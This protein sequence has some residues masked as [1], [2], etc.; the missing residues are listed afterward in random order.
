M[1]SSFYRPP[2]KDITITSSI[3]RKSSSL[4]YGQTTPHP[5]TDFES[6]PIEAISSSTA[7][8]FPDLHGSISSSNYV[9]NITQSW[10][11]SILGPLGYGVL[12]RKS[13]RLNSSHSQQ[14]RMPSS[15]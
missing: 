9:I 15:A 10:S 6:F 3:G 12:D 7:G 4:Y 5:S 11:S 2:V 14:S 8:V 1:T 13:T